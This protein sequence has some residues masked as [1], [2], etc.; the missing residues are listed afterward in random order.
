MKV[1]NTICSFFHWYDVQYSGMSIAHHVEKNA[2]NHIMICECTVIGIMIT[3][4]TQC[5]RIH[6]QYY[7][8]VLHN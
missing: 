7:Y 5:E 4:Y 1:S 3:M 8:H 6:M 2:R